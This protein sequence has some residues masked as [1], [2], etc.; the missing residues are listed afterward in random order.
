MPATIILFAG[1]ARSYMEP[2]SVACSLP[3]CL[4]FEM[5]PERYSC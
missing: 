4:T 3:P 5:E 2:I 1:M